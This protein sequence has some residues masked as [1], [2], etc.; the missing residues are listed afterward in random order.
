MR[1]GPLLLIRNHPGKPQPLVDVY[2][3]ALKDCVLAEQ[4]GFDLCLVA[5]HHFEPISGR[6]RR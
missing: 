5:E 3:E 1:V 2:E 4:L 6:L